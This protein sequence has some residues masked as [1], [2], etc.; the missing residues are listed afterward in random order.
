MLGLAGAALFYGDGMITPAISVL[1]AVEGLE[2][3]TPA[4]RAY[5]VPIA[6]VVLVGLF[7]V[8]SRGSER[9]GAFF[10]PIMAAWFA[11]L[12]IA[13]LLQ[14]VQAPGVVA[15]LDPTY[16]VVQFLGT[17]GWTGTSRPRFGVSGA[18]WS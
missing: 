17:H 14:V 15:A 16:G 10:G 5:V 8:Q 6:V 13:G 11:T 4:L 7:V 3:A 18:D 12:A 1:S 9:I 2:V